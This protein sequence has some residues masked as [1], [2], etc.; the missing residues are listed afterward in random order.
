MHYY[1]TRWTFISV[2][3]GLDGVG[4]YHATIKTSATFKEMLTGTSND[5]AE[6]FIKEFSSEAEMNVYMERR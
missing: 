5:L 3:D 1:Y 2:P 6:F 4:P